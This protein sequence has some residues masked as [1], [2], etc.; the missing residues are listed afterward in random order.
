MASDESLQ[1]TAPKAPVTADHRVNPNLDDQLPKPFLPRALAA[2]DTENISGTVPGHNHNGMSV[3]QQHVA[4]FDRNNDGIVYPWETYMGFRAVGFNIILSFVGSF[5]I[6]LSMSYPT[7]PGWFPSPFFPIYID[8]IHRAKH[9]SDS[10]VYDT[11]GRIANKVEWILA[12]ILA[13]D[14]EGSL[15]KEAARGVFDGSLFEY[16]EKQR[17]SRKND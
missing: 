7:L 8:R 9:G 4:F 6:N 12:Y 11:E 17:M 10:E 16:C 3:L 13:K 15:P 14:D 1:T 2:V 5:L